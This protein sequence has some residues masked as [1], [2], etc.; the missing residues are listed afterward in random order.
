MTIPQL[1]TDNWIAIAAIVIPILIAWIG[2]VHLW[3]WSLFKKDFL[4]KKIEVISPSLDKRFTS[5]NKQIRVLPY[6][7]KN[8]KL[9]IKSLLLNHEALCQDIP[10]TAGKLREEN[11]YIKCYRTSDGNGGT[12]LFPD[13]GYELNIIPAKEVN[14]TLSDIIDDW[15]NKAEKIKTYTDK[16]KIEFISRFHVYFQMIHPFLDG[17]GRIGRALLE[18]QLSYLFD[19]IIKFNPNIQ[20]YHQSVESAIKGDES[21][22]RQIISK[23]I[24][25]NKQTTQIIA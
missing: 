18:E 9:S 6:L 20:L 17:N 3:I 7:D 24:K 4:D 15:N 14:L 2:N 13:D 8:G 21:E 19:H 22:L 23:E 10:N 25:A 5:L 1:S 11:V 16:E 12:T